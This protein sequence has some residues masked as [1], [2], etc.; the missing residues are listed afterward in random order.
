MG[1]DN[2]ACDLPLKRNHVYLSSNWHNIYTNNVLYQCKRMK[3]IKENSKEEGKE[4]V[5]QL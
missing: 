1:T 4:R 5:K 2:L 3:E